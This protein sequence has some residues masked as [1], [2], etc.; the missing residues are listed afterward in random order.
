MSQNNQV[1]WTGSAA[2][3]TVY[4]RKDLRP[5]ASGVVA[6]LIISSLPTCNYQGHD[7]CMFQEF[8]I[9]LEEQIKLR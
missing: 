5:S 6:Y 7:Y 9:L 8:R 2:D 1:I 4:C 3:K